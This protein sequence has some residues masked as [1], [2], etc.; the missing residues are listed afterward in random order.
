MVWIGRD[1][2]D[3]KAPTPQCYRQG[4]LPLEQVAHSPIQL[5]LEHLQGW[6]VQNLSGQPVAAPYHL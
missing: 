3:H 4:H 5:G 6:G 2:K 1:L